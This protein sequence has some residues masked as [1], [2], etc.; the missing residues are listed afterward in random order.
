M[1]WGKKKAEQ[2]RDAV[3]NGGTLSGSDARR[4]TQQG[5]LGDDQ[6]VRDTRGRVTGD[7]SGRTRKPTN[8]H[9]V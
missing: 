4:A 3:T 1:A 6:R 8:E 2:R 7:F 9:G 5:G